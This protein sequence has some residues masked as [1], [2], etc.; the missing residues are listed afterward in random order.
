MTTPKPLERPCPNALATSGSLPKLQ[1]RISNQGASYRSVAFPLT[2]NPSCKNST[3]PDPPENAHPS[4]RD[5]LL[6]DQLPL[7]RSIASRIRR[8]LPNHLPFED[9]LQAGTIGLLDAIAKYDPR[10]ATRFEVYASSRIRGAILDSLR[11]LDWAP[12]GLRAKA[13]GL[14]KA[15][16]TLRF[17]LDRNASEPELATYLGVTLSALH[18]LI[19]E[20]ARLRIQCS[21][22]G[23]D[24][25]EETLYECTPAKPEEIP[26]LVYLRSETIELLTRAIAELPPKQRQVIVL[27]YDKQLTMKKVGSVLGI[28]E[29]RVSQLHSMAV[30]TLRIWFSERTSRH[31]PPVADHGRETGDHATSLDSRRALL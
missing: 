15:R 30:V 14:E 26:L 16:S 27:Y 9:L 29:S 8:R 23:A 13:R 25:R 4:E 5:K 11:N 12:R 21:G 3:V 17:D 20:I 10:K 22:F 19:G 24:G 31:A 2:D 7:V 6:M 1:L 28:S 18:L